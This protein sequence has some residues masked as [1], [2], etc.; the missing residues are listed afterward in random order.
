MVEKGV[1]RRGEQLNKGTEKCDRG[2][3]PG[4][5]HFSRLDKLGKR[6]RKSVCRIK[7]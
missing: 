3:D 4:W 2:F 7:R 1:V 6:G 5:L